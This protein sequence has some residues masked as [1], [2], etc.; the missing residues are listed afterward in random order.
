MRVPLAPS[1]RNASILA[2]FALGILPVSGVS[3][4]LTLGTAL[5]S[6]L[7]T[8][9]SMRAAEARVE[10]ADAVRAAARAAFLPTVAGSTGLTRHAEPMVVAPLHGFDP[11][12]PPDFDRTLIQSQLGMELT[13]FDGGGRRAR[14]R[15]AEAAEETLALGRDATED[16]LLEAVVAA[17]TG[18]LATRGLDEAARRL[19]EALTA[20]LDRARQRF[21]E[22]TAA[23]VEVMRAEAALLDA[24]AQL[25]SA[26]A[27]VVLAE[28]GLARLMG[29][30]PTSLAGRPL[31]DLTPRSTEAADPI[32]ADPRVEAA[33]RNVDAV[34]ARLSQE[35]AGRL[36]TLRATAGL[37]NFG[38]GLGEYTTEW[39]AG[40]RVSW[41]LFTG[42]ARSAAIHRAEADLHVAQEELRQAEMGVAGALD[43]AEAAL[44][45]A[46]A[47]VEAL[48]A[49]VAQWEEVARIEVLSLETGS[50]VQQ[51]L[52]RAEAALYQARA[53]RARARY[54]EILAHVGRARAQGRLDRA[55]MDDALEI[56]R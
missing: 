45:E 5:D 19:V 12:R 48:E 39:Q 22:G 23:R 32:R 20:E 40:V 28:K 43:G 35:R 37:L 26:R 34:R 31:A 36:P 15:G 38:S 8:H 13:L 16:D 2:T 7:A 3:Q 17:Y 27:R 51:D 52:L 55:W 18:V 14:V 54:D 44:A 41:P 46:T 25:A 30:D 6:T 50:G 24:Q 1:L 49:S 21:A 53:G 9:P 42:G 10:G 56:R 4:V 47:R 11:T 29:A 33:R